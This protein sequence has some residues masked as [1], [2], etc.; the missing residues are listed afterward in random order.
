MPTLI[1]RLTVDA[2]AIEAVRD[3]RDFIRD[4]AVKYQ[5]E[6]DAQPGQG[7]MH[8]WYEGRASAFEQ[9]A[10]WLTNDLQLVDPAE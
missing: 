8:G 7:E 1:R 10:D 3:T 6:A 2:E 5:A 4:E 9:V